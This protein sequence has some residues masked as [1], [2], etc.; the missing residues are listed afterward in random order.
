M[1]FSGM[2]NP[3]R[4]GDMASAGVPDLEVLDFRR[5]ENA[6]EALRR[7][8]ER[9]SSPAVATVLPSTNLA[10]EDL[11]RLEAAGYL[12]VEMPEEL[13]SANADAVAQ[14]VRDFVQDGR[15]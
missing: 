5:P 15:S 13:S 9:A 4:I 1:Y 11:V 7:R 10:F 12:V 8:V 6:R 3:M 2:S 14:F